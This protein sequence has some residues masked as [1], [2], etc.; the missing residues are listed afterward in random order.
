MN[1][2]GN[3]PDHVRRRSHSDSTRLHQIS[4]QEPWPIEQAT[5][6]LFMPACRRRRPERSIV[7]S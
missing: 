5:R 6:S 3:S 7:C 2:V 1:S 4:A